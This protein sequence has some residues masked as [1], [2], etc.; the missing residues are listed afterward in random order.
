MVKLILMSLRVC[1]VVDFIVIEQMMK[2]K[3]HSSKNLFK[4]YLNFNCY[5]YY[6]IIR[7]LDK[8]F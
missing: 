5:Y 3:M 1:L 8:G 7:I 4:I 6:Y 2:L